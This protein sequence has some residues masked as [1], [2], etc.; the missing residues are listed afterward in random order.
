MTGIHRKPLPEN[1]PES[2]P[3]ILPEP[4]AEARP[5]LRSGQR[6]RSLA[7]L[8]VWMYRALL[9]PDRLADGS[10][11]AVLAG[12][13]R[14]S[15]RDG[16]AIYQR[17]YLIRLIAC[18]R[19]QF[20]ALCH[21]LGRPLF[22][23]FAEAYLAACPPQS[24]TLQDLG[25]RL[26]AFLEE[27]RPDAGGVEAVGP[28]AGECTG[29]QE[30]WVDFMVDLA[31]YERQVTVLFDRMCPDAGPPARCD[32]P[33]AHLSLQPCFDLGAYRFPVAR[34]C[35]SVRR[36]A[37]P[38][39]PPARRCFAA[40]V[41]KDY[42]P[43]TV[44]LGAADFLFLSALRDGLTVPKALA[45]LAQRLDMPLSAVRHGWRAADGVRHKWIAAGFFVCDTRAATPA[46]A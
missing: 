3:D 42:R 36:G 33:D 30:P 20:P 14:L 21:A 29:I 7:D 27:N 34:Y 16:L 38:D 9:R 37:R 24:Y 5:M 31:T 28:D 18:L 10:A 46:D 25:H 41:R 43:L 15:G 17:G 6:P 12:D 22:D 45:R 35:D 44:P 39:P 2:L 23:G 26:P 19:E 40:L 1:L 4:R 11:E 8:Q 13:G 32:T